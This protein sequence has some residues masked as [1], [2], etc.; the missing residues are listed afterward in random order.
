MQLTRTNRNVKVVNNHSMLKCGS[1][2]IGERILQTPTSCALRWRKLE[3]WVIN[4]LWMKFTHGVVTFTVC[5]SLKEKYV[6]EVMKISWRRERLPERTHRR[7]SCVCKRRW[8]SPWMVRCLFFNSVN[9][10][11]KILLLMISFFEG[12]VCSMKWLTWGRKDLEY[13]MM[14]DELRRMGEELV[15]TK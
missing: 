4:I 8:K 7:P 5:F 15:R 6:K 13:E 12:L 11:Y 3:W 14:Q 9:V 1:M 2:V 10:R